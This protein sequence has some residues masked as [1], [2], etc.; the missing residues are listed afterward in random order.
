MY[1]GF[2]PEES[3]ESPKEI[4]GGTEEIHYISHHLDSFKIYFLSI[5]SPP[6]FI[7]LLP[8]LPAFI[9]RIL[10]V[11]VRACV[12]VWPTK[13]VHVQLEQVF[14]NKPIETLIRRKLQ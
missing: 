9:Q 2:S 14:A 4:S 11:C 10:W 5:N 7:P 6:S 1:S 13:P 12:F 3:L 8:P